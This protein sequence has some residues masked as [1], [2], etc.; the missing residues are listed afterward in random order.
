MNKEK[1]FSLYMVILTIVIILQGIG[2]MVLLHL[3]NS[4]V[5]A[6]DMLEY[7]QDEEWLECHIERDG[8]SYHV[9][10]LPDVEY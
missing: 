5:D 10:C 8:L 1:D 4:F 3:H 9:Y 6:V 2:M 7:A